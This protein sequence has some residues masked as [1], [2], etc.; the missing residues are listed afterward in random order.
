MENI[1][2]YAVECNSLYGIIALV[3]IFLGFSIL[4]CIAYKI[5]QLILPYLHKIICKHYN[6][7]KEYKEVHTKFGANDVSYET[8]LHR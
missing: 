8:D 1:I 7:I 6:I 5:I 3:V 4:G 2:K